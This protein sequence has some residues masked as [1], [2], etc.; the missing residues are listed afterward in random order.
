[1]VPMEWRAGVVAGHRT[2][3]AARQAS[4]VVAHVTLQ[5][6]EKVFREWG[7]MRPSKSP[8]DRLAKSLPPAGRFTFTYIRS[9]ALRAIRRP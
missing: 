8:L 7:R 9:M 2:R 4:V 1:M 6:G 5:E 3:L